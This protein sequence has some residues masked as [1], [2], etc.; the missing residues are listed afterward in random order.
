MNTYNNGMGGVNLSNQ[1][2]SSYSLEHKRLRKWLKKMRLHLVNTCVF[3]SQ[4]LHLKRGGKLST[5]EFRLKLIRQ[6]TEKY[7]YDTD[8]F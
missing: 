1:I 4:V 3:N 7:G 6:I 2:M 8:T 5:L